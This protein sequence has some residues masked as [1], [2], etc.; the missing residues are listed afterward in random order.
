[1]ALSSII[2]V[3]VSFLSGAAISPLPKYS[4]YSRS[5]FLI[6]WFCL[7]VLLTGMRALLKKIYLHYRGVKGGQNE[8]TVLI[9]GAGDAGE[10]CL[11]YLKKHTNPTYSVMD[12]IDDDLSKR[13]KRL[14][15][16]K[17]VGNRHHLEIL[18]KL[19]IEFRSN[20]FFFCFGPLLRQLY[21]LLIKLFPI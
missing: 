12:F 9:W 1:V 5:V 19:N 10:I 2:L 4:S 13:S 17:I 21:F 6:D 8:K 7:T 11:H 15:G 3:A 16:V 18:A 20:H 14:N